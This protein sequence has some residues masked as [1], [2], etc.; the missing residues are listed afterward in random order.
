MNIFEAKRK[1]FNKKYCGAILIWIGNENILMQNV[2]FENN[3]ATIKQ[4]LNT[5]IIIMNMI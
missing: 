2:Y 4:Q 5:E 3:K 1:F